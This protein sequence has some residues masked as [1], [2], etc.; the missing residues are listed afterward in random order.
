MIQAPKVVTVVTK[1]SR[2]QTHPPAM[3][4]AFA[5]FSLAR[6]TNRRT[7]L[8]SCP[9]GGDFL[10]ILSV[11]AYDFKVLPFDYSQRRFG[12]ST[13]PRIVDTRLFVNAYNFANIRERLQKNLLTKRPSTLELKL[14]GLSGGMAD[15]G[16]L[17]SPACNGRAGSSPALAI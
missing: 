6:K 3:Q 2:R 5:R 11:N 10:G 13:N 9:T 16:D 4:A 15:A 1:T 8:S 14:V 17:K 12:N 7:S